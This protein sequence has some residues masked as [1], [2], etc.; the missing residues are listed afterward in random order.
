ME[1]LTPKQEKFAQCVADG[2]SQSEAYRNA[3]NVKSTT[4]PESI[5]Q[6][7]S[8]LMAD[9]KVRSRV[10]ELKEKLSE[11]ALWTREQSVKALQNAMRIA[12]DKDNPTGVVAAV[13]ELNAMHGFIVNKTEL[14]GK[15]GK[16]LVSEAPKGVL[17]V[18]GV[19][20]D[21]DWKKM[22]DKSK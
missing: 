19:M 11:K 12:E 16:D 13:K 4:K 15:D 2:M 6:K 18:P 5:H 14:T 9:V 21:A 22:M 8:S 3:F 17:I 10:D 20:S 7:A 1:K